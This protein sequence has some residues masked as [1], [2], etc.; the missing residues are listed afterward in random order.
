MLENSSKSNNSINFILH[1]NF[2]LRVYK[3]SKKVPDELKDV[4]TEETFE[5]ARLYGIDKAQF[6][7]FKSILCDILIVS[8][9]LYF[10]F[11]GYLWNVARSYTSHI[12][13]NPDSEIYVSCIFLII[14]N[15]IGVVKELPFSIFST[16]VL[17]EKHGFNKQ[18]A[19]FYVKD[20]IKAFFV[21][22]I[23]TSEF[24]VFLF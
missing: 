6:E 23:I 21:G 9:E 22:Q 3:T 13:L 10:G 1:L 11:V 18:T 19:A 24:E 4:M 2:Q 7:I 12:H 20:Q 17:E 16:F 15:L 5:K 8:T 14:V